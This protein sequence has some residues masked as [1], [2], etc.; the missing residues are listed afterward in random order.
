[1]SI[2]QMR[3][4][5]QRDRVLFVQTQGWSIPLDWNPDLPLKDIPLYFLNSL[6]E[7]EKTFLPFVG[8]LSQG[9]K[10]RG[11]QEWWAAWRG[12]GLTLTGSTQRCRSAV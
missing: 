5:A 8:Q 6:Y 4:I 2:L 11:C 3:I 1:M 7:K 9:M 12:L 10:V